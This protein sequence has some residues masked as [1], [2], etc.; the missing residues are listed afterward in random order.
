MAKLVI[1]KKRRKPAA[2]TAKRGLSAAGKKATR[3][4]GMRRLG[5]VSTDPPSGGT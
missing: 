1:K 3:R 2:K 5:T 4:M